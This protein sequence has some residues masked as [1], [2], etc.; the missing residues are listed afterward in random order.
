MMQKENDS[1]ASESDLLGDPPGRLS[2][3][4]PHEACQLWPACAILPRDGL[5]TT[6]FRLF[7]KTGTL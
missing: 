4:L 3:Q 2:G 7:M 5:P 6:I 1:F